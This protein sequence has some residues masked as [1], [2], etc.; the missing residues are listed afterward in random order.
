MRWTKFVHFGPSGRLRQAES[1]GA[2]QVPVVD[3]QAGESGGRG[4]SELLEEAP[5]DCAGLV[6]GGADPCGKPEHVHVTCHVAMRPYPARLL[7]PSLRLYCQI[8][9][10]GVI[11]DG[12]EGDALA[13]HEWLGKRPRRWGRRGLVVP[14]LSWW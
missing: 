13:G 6:A 7:V 9:V 5:F 8:L 11:L 1:S 3:P 4:G 2:Q 10:S 14:G 12:H